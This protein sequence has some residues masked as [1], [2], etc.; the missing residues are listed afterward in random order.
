MNFAATDEG[1]IAVN[2]GIDF[3]VLK[4]IVLARLLLVVL[5]LGCREPGERV[6]KWPPV[7]VSRFQLN[8]SHVALF[9]F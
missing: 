9:T 6:Q 4:T 1:F 2:Y 3:A 5:F 8:V 7:G